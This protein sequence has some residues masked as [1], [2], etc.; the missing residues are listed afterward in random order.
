MRA[1]S[2]GEEPVT[3]GD[4]HD[5]VIGDSRRRHRAHH[6]FLP[7]VKVAFCVSD[8]NRLARGAA[9]CVQADNVLERA[10]EQTERISVA[11]IRLDRERQVFH[12]VQ[13]LD[14]TG[15]QISVFHAFAVKGHIFV[16]PPDDPGKTLRLKFPEFFHRQIVRRTDRIESRIPHSF[17]L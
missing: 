16:C 12:I 3:E 7:Y 2:A 11:E 6:G 4:L 10:C 5:V 1:E 17:I 9:G 15:R 14:V 13:A 8:D